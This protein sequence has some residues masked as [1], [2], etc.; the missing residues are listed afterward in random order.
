M[1]PTPV[2]PERA[3]AAAPGRG[4]G[5]RMASLRLYVLVFT[6]ALMLAA[7]PNAGAIVGGT[8]VS[9]ADTPVV[10]V[11]QISA[12]RQACTGVALSPTLVLTA[13]HCGLLADG[14]APAGQPFAV[15]KGPSVGAPTLRSGGVFIP[16]P[17]FSWGGSGVPHFADADLAVIRIMGPPIPGPYATLGSVDGKDKGAL[18]IYGYGVSALIGGEADP[19]SFGTLRHASAKSLGIKKSDPEFLHFNG[20]ACFGD[21]GGPV[22]RDGVL[23]AVISF[24]PSGCHSTNY[25]TR[26]DTASARGFLAQFGF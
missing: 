12:P 14:T 1:F 17:D 18:D 3:I 7:V 6:A 8:A 22:M 5:V 23:L 9:G 20:P 19:A 25:A 4:H 24:A 15:F 16:H 21:S 10:F 13:A 2:S 26:V 11:G